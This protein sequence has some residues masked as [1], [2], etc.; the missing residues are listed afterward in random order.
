MTA[1]PKDAPDR[2][3][4]ETS[5]EALRPAHRPAFE[6]GPDH[7]D[8]EAWAA[9]AATRIS[10]TD[11]R[12]LAKGTASARSRIRKEK[13]TGQRRS[14]GAARAPERGRIRE[15]VIMD[16]VESKFPGIRRS[17]SVLVHAA[18]PRWIASPDGLDED[19]VV[20]VKISE[21]DLAPGPLSPDRTLLGVVQDS[22]FARTGY[23]DQMQWQMFVTGMP[24]ALFVWEQHDGQW[25]HPLP[26][27]PIPRWCWVPRND[28]RID[29][30]ITVAESFLRELEGMDATSVEPGSL[31][32][33]VATAAARYRLALE[34][35][36]EAKERKEAAIREVTE[37]MLA[38][39][40][41][42]V[43][44]GFGLHVTCG[45]GEPKEVR[46]FNDERARE[47]APAT[48]A[49]WLAWRERY[50][51]TT[52]EPGRTTVRITEKG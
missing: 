14:L 25:P 19:A 39:T 50:T 30:L 4:W 15:Q 52:T 35:E 45:T 16:W 3:D 24:Q 13:L 28:E 47:K 37:Y 27:H 26:L 32:R 49:K 20:E 10:A 12:E 33:E 43:L 8:E 2:R 38:H 44:D 22:P 51:D 29:H 7:A 42:P 11:V 46:S 6:V 5:E 41:T 34:E 31:P 40:D 48:Y 1:P 9:F 21:D 17:S 23:Y 18:D 36:K